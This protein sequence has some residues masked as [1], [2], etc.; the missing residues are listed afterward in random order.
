VDG[1]SISI[2]PR[3]IGTPGA[4]LRIYSD[5]PPATRWRKKISKALRLRWRALAA[6]DHLRKC[7]ATGEESALL[8]TSTVQYGGIYK[9]GM[10]CV[11]TR[12]WNSWEGSTSVDGAIGVAMSEKMRIVCHKNSSKRPPLPMIGT[13]FQSANRQMNTCNCR[14]QRATKVRQEV[15]RHIVQVVRVSQRDV[16]NN[17][18]FEIRVGHS[19]C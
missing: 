9:R 16:V 14:R 8:G 12:S 5:P 11:R 10:A 1:Y 13:Y 3:R 17:Y 19:R 15:A 18:Q 7:Q 6:D 4:S 2:Q